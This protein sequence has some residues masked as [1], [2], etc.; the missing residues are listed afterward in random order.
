MSRNTIKKTIAIILLQIV[1][2]AAF[3]QFA[4]I[5][6]NG[7]R[8]YSDQPPPASIP[9][10]KILKD[11]GSSCATRSRHRRRQESQRPTQHPK[12]CQR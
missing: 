7:V 5:D 8:Q 11:S 12:A 9:K 1:A 4:W 3:A 10:N 6:P 2:G